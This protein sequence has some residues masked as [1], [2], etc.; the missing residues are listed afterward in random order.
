MVFNWPSLDWELFVG[1]NCSI[2]THSSTQDAFVHFIIRW[3]DVSQCGLLGAFLGRRSGLPSSPVP[4]ECP[5]LQPSGVALK[6]CLCR[7]PG[8]GTH[9]PPGPMGLELV[10]QSQGPLVVRL[11]RTLTFR[12]HLSSRHPYEASSPSR[13]QRRP[14]GW[15]A[16]YTGVHFHGVSSSSQG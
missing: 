6:L 11:P 15:G 4:Q 3:V 7:R 1:K 14:E 13:H 2:S 10:L 9:A 16:S 5:H 8:A 12:L